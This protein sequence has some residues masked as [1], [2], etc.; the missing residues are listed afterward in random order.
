MSQRAKSPISKDIQEDPRAK[1]SKEK[2]SRVGDSNGI[3]FSLT[4]TDSG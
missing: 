4:G 3:I 2:D 1:C